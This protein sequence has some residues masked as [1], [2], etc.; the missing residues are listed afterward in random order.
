MTGFLVVRFLCVV[1]RFFSGK[2][3]LRGGTARNVTGKGS[4]CRGA[5]SVDAS[6]IDR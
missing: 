4:G 3:G 2:V 1:V 5:V 6:E